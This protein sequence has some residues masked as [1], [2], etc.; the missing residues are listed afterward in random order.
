MK[1]IYLVMV[2]I[3]LMVFLMPWPDEPVI[4]TVGA[5]PLV[6]ALLLIGAIGWTLVG[7]FDRDRR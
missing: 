3:N 1:P 6:D 4:V 5:R 7:L 2:A